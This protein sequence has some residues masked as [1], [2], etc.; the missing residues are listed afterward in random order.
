VLRKIVHVGVGLVAGLVLGVG[1]MLVADR[2][3]AAPVRPPDCGVPLHSA[4]GDRRGDDDLVA[5]AWAALA[6]QH[7]DL[8]GSPPELGRSCLAFAGDT[9]AGP[10]VV[11]VDTTRAR[12]SSLGRIVEVRVP[13]DGPV[14]FAAASHSVPYAAELATGAVLPLSG[15]YLA[16]DQPGKATRVSVLSSADGYAEA[17]SAPEV[18][19]GLFDVGIAADMAGRVANPND[20]DALL[21]VQMAHREEPVAVAVPAG[22]ERARPLPARAT[23]ALELRGF[24]AVDVEALRAVG[25]ALSAMSADARYPLLRDLRHR[26]PALE[27]RTTGDEVT[28]RAADAPAGLPEFTVVVPGADR[29]PDERDR[30]RDD[31]DRADRDADERPDQRPDERPDERDEPRGTDDED[32]PTPSRFQ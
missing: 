23:Y 21:L 24:D 4:H 10:T 6:A 9:P 22:P 17:R 1:S 15:L 31:R 20:P 27:A 11:L 14:R 18:A 2:W 32:P 13:D 16:P 5:R 19:D 28:I 29:D 7:V 25:P 12:Y 30:N 8:D 3:T 26:P